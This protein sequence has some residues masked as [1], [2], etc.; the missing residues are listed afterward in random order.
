M[1]MSSVP[2]PLALEIARLSAP[3]LTFL[4]ILAAGRFPHFGLFF[5]RGNTHV[6]EFSHGAPLKVITIKN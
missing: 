2:L 6:I 3:A 5:G 1:A 4:L